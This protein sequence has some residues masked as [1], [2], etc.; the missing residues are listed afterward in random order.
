MTRIERWPS[1]T[2]GRSRTVRHGDTVHT[3]ANARRLPAPFDDQVVESL[4]TLDAH[5]AEAGTSRSRLLS[6]QVLLT[7]IAQR[8]AFDRRWLAWIGD[9]PAHWPQRACFQAALAPGLLIELV[10]VAA[11]DPG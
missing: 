9:D 2:P 6:I 5:L 4:A 3:V 1:G 8:P 7:D 11:A 10:A